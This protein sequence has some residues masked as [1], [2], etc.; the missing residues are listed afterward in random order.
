[1]KLHKDVRDLWRGN[2]SVRHSEQSEMALRTKMRCR[3]NLGLALWTFPPSHLINAVLSR[4]KMF[5]IVIGPASVAHKGVA[6]VL[7]AKVELGC[8]DVF[9]VH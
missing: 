8:A 5:G 4:D 2:H 3:G 7:G 9:G 6:N 1:V